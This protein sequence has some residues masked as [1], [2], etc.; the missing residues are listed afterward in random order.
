MLADH[1]RQVIERFRRALIE[2]GVPVAQTIL[3]G[4]RARGVHEP[5][6]DYDVL[7]VLDRLDQDIERA[8]SRCAR[9]ADYAEHF[10][11]SPVVVTKDD[12]EKSPFRSS[13]LMQAVRAEGLSIGPGQAEAAYLGESPPEW[14]QPVNPEDLRALVRARFDQ[15]TESLADAQTLLAAQGSGRSIV[16]RSYYAMFYCVLALL[17]TINRVPRKHRGAISLFDREFV[18]PGLLPRELSADLHRVFQTRQAEDYIEV[19]PVGFDEAQCALD[20]AERFVAAVRDYL[21]GAGYL[22][23]E[24]G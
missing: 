5:D 9:E 19:A 2:Q 10:S 22:S 20:A 14:G 21:S 7:V 12:L 13:L 16:N 8:I 15:V 3:F 18:R 1:D 23:E 11:I 4:S 17:Q 6:S 24:S